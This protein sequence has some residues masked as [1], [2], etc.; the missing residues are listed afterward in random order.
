MDYD[1]EIRRHALIR[2]M[3]RGIDPDQIEAAIKGGK[4][5]YFAKNYVRFIMQYKDF[6]VI[7]IGEICG[8]RI[9]IITIERG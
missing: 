5:H 8:L 6:K 1:I 4:R 3:Q 7:C 9:K 2:A